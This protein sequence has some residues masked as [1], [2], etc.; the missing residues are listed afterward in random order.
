MYNG[1]LLVNGGSTLNGWAYISG[2]GTLQVGDGT[3]NGSV[4]G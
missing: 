4:T 3:T 1:M 2:G